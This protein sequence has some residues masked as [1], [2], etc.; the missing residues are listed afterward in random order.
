M[1]AV[2]DFNKLVNLAVGVEGYT[3]MRPVI[4]KELLHYDILFA[5]ERAALL[6]QRFPPKWAGT[7]S[8]ILCGARSKFALAPKGENR[9][10]PPLETPIAPV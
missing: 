3:H 4:V 1:K 6:D 10:S 9:D 2:E 5:L 7:A 8:L